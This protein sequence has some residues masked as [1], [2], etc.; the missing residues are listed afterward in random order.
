MDHQ[1]AVQVNLQAQTK[2]INHKAVSFPLKVLPA[3][4]LFKQMTHEDYHFLALFTVGIPQHSSQLHA[5][6]SWRQP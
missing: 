2:R 4:Y 3:F 1:F 6:D 5:L